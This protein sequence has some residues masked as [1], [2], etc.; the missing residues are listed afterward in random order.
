MQ[1]MFDFSFDD[2]PRFVTH[3]VT[4]ILARME[5]QFGNKPLKEIILENKAISAFM[6]EKIQKSGKAM[7]HNV[8]QTFHYLLANPEIS[9]AKL[10]YIC[11]D[12]NIMQ[13][14]TIERGVKI[15]QFY[16]DDV[17]KMTEIYNASNVNKPLKTMPKPEP[18]CLFDTNVFRFE[19]NFRVEYSNYLTMLYG[20][21]TP[22]DFRMTWQKNV[23]SWNR[24]FKRCVKGENM[25]P[26][27][28]SIIKE[29]SKLWPEWDKWVQ[30]AKSVGA[31]M[32]EEELEEVE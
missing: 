24:V 20:Y 30:K 9:Q 5:K 6:S 1:Q 25:T 11:K 28:L 14:F 17:T 2:M 29:A 18:E 23:T 8:L 15:A 19:K 16:R 3:A 12:D 13:E 22:E 31:F 21:A 10:N 26:A 7:P 27:N 4:H 32:T